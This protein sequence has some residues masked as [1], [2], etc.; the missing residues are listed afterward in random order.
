MTTKA[1]VGIAALA[2]AIAGVSAGVTALV[3]TESQGP[4]VP[5]RIP[6]EPHKEPVRVLHAQ[7]FD[8][9]KPYNHLWRKERPPVQS[10]WL[11]VLAVPPDLVFARQ[12]HEPVLYVGSQT[13]E[14]VNT[15]YPSGHLVV[16]APGDY[17]LE[18]VPIFFGDRLPPEEVGVVEIERQL[19]RAQDAGVEPPNH[20]QVAGVTREPLQ[21]RSHR[22]LHRVAI[23]L[24]ERYSPQERDLI[25][26]NR[27]EVVR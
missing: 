13:A 16:I 10:G 3:S 5:P 8:L 18:D 15:G 27:V 17:F 11:L 4:A 19:R 24:V 14:R 2:V 25:A 9:A 22:E 12:S 20:S 21:L 23:D 6:A 7:R 26:G 1:V